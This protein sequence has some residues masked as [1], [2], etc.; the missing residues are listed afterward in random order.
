MKKI[1]MSVSIVLISCLCS[2]LP[3]PVYAAEA[4]AGI[5]VATAY[6]F[7]GHTINDSWVAQPYIDVGR[8]PG[9]DGLTFGAWG[10]FDLDEGSSGVPEAG[11][12][13]EIDLYTAYD[14]PT[15]HDIYTFSLAYIEYL[16]PNANADADR[17]LNAIATLNT[18]LN[19]SLGVYWGVDGAIDEQVYLEG[20]I[21]HEEDIGSDVTLF[22]GSTVGVVFQ[23]QENKD[24]DDGFSYA[25]FDAGVGYGMARASVTVYL[26][27][28]DK[29]LTVDEDVVGM[30]SVIGTF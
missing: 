4:A 17:E 12:F 15:D 2:Q 16:Y 27:T 23:G 6:V 25:A 9:A 13:S 28:D 26:E 10:N 19:P 24:A 1:C 30:L 18:I 8:I 22:A 21:G 29:V 5:D 20:N 7:R 3:Q 14:F 11:Q